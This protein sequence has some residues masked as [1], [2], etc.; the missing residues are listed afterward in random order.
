MTP[1]RHCI[2]AKGKALDTQN[3]RTIYGEHGRHFLGHK[4]PVSVQPKS[5]ILIHI[6]LEILDKVLW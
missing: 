4:T 2:E 3:L 1:C 6:T 5:T